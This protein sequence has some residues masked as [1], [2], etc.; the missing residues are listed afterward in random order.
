MQKFDALEK[1]N[2]EQRLKYMLVMLE[3][4]L[5]S[6]SDILANLSN[7]TAI[8]KVVI[9]ELNWAGFYFFYQLSVECW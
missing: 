2:E 1:M 4:Q 3:G 7:A 6:E 9:K 8:I 5:S